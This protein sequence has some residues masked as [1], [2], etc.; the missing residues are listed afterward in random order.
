MFGSIDT[1]DALDTGVG[2]GA[3]V[4]ERDDGADA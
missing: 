1:L 3:G 4:D 2:P